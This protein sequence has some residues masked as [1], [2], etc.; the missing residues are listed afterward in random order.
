MNEILSIIIP[1]KNIISSGLADD[2]KL[3]LQLLKLQTYKHIECIVVDAASTDGTVEFL[4]RCQTAGR[5]TFVSEP[6]EG[7]FFA[8][9]KGIKKA[10]GKYVML[11]SCDDFLHD[12][13]ALT[14]VADIFEKEDADFIVS[15]SY[16]RHPQG[17]TFLF[18]PSIY[19]VFQVMPCPRQAIVFKKEVLEKEGLFDTN[20]KNM[21]DFD[22]IIRLML[23][24][25]KG[26]MFNKNFVTYKAGQKL[27]ENPQLEYE[28][29]KKVF[30]KNYS[31]IY[32][33]NE[34]DLDKMLKISDFPK[35]LLE[36]LAT[37]FPEADREKFFETCEQLKLIRIN[38]IKKANENKE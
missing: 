7:K 23:K 11:L 18:V 20:I 14:D 32:P 33:L 2:F 1:T 24:K 4:N 38:A 16:C 15:P 13:T 10:N 6:D 12:I 26:I 29:A 28:D 35:P 37:R 9:N 5:L 34:E 19:N 3:F 36:K 17:F 31:K 25:Y 27:I 30:V 8:Y 21:A 22:L